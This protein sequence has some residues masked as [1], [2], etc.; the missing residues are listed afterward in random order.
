MTE[1]TDR[2]VLIVQDASYADVQMYSYAIFDIEEK[3]TTLVG[4]RDISEAFAFTNVL[5]NVNAGREY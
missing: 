4:L 5:N 1:D 2:F 3:V